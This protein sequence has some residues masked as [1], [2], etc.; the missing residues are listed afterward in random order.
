M[1]KDVRAAAVVAVVLSVAMPLCGQTLRGGILE[2]LPGVAVDNGDFKSEVM[3][4][5]LDCVLKAA[6]LTVNWHTYPTLR[7]LKMLNATEL[8]I[9]FPMGF[10]A[11]RDQSMK[12]SDYTFR[13]R[14]I[15]A[16]KGSAPNF[17]DKDSLKVAA[18]AGS[19]Q[20]D[21]LQKQ[22]YRMLS[23]PNSYDA[24]PRMLSSGHI[25]AF[26]VTE[27]LLLDMKLAPEFKT[28]LILER[29]VGFYLPKSTDAKML[30]N[31]NSAIKG[32][33]K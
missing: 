8:D 25:A 17:S 18:K 22:G 15:W 12:R 11:E 33:R 19:P 20:A 16:F 2:S 6:G 13:S 4:P 10:T 27:R 30:D 1:K 5:M 9:A 24:L 7:L 14:D 31:L 26:A 29:D 28:A 23:L 3:G 32:C 21:Y